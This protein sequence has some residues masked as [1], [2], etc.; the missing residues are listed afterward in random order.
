MLN[1]L[2]L[3]FCQWQHNHCIDMLKA[4]NKSG[5]VY[6]AYMYQRDAQKWGLR[7]VKASAK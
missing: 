7:A 6:G 4:C 1:K 2:W 5:D 3:A